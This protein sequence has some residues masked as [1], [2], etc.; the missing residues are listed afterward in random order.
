MAEE[1]LYRREGLPWYGLQLPDSTP[2]T[3]IPGVERRECVE[4][5]ESTWQNMIK[6]SI[7]AWVS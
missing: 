1:A 2:A 6:V 4:S 7:Q 5:V 3:V